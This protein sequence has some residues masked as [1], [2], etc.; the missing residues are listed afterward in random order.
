MQAAEITAHHA[1]VLIIIQF[2]RTARLP[3]VK[4][5]IEAL[6]KQMIQRTKDLTAK[7]KETKGERSEMLLEI[8]RI[9]TLYDLPFGDG[10]LGDSLIGTFNQWTAGTRLAGERFFEV[11]LMEYSVVGENHVK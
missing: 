3:R 7:E 4:C 1:K 5:E 6:E 9:E 10:V 11:I 2:R 8:E